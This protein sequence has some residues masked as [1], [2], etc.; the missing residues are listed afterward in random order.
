MSVKR[1][2]LWSAARDELA[3][4]RLGDFIELL[5]PRY[6]RARRSRAICEHL[7]AIENGEIERLTIFMPPRH[8]S[9][10]A[11]RRSHARR[12]AGTPTAS[13]G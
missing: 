2:A 7:E 8:G 4:R 5:E 3:R 10:V 11:C 12:T 1:T 6:E 9:S 13:R